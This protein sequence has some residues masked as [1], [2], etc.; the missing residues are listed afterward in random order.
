M[1]KRSD[2]FSGIGKRNGIKEKRED[3]K[4]KNCG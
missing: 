1:K 4:Q 3:E 2:P